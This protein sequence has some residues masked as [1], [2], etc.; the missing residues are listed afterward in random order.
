MKRVTDAVRESL[1]IKVFLVC[2]AAV[3]I[4]LIALLLYLGLDRPSDPVPILI[5]ALAATLAGCALSLVA[6]VRFVSPIDRLV[7]A[8]DR[9]QQEGV[10]PIVEV[11]GHDGVRRLAEKLLSLVRMQEQ[12]MRT[13]RIQ[14]N[15][16][17][18]TGLGNRRWLYN[19]ASVELNRAQRL[20]Q[21]V[22]IIMFDLDHFKSVNDTYGHGAGDDVLM[23][24]AEIT[25]R[26]LRPYDLFARLGGEEFCIVASDKSPELGPILAERVRAAI[27]NSSPVVAGKAARITASIG[28]HKG[29]PTS[30]SFSDMVRQAD[31]ALYEA[32]A[33]GRNRVVV[34]SGPTTPRSLVGS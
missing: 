9:Y 24:V 5:V 19:A 31:V 3:H 23:T 4:P 14:A 26:Q 15:S 28:V 11:G 12:H 22:W 16:D 29:D 21:G 20:D 30:E 17:A 10:E 27:E 13:L 2:F 6:I 18:L 33:K 8:V 1:A 25:L 32:K 7:K 34:G